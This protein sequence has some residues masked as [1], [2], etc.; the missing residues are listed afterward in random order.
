MDNQLTFQFD[1]QQTADRFL[2]LIKRGAVGRAQ[3]RRMKGGFQILVS[4]IVPDDS[5]FDGTCQMLD[6]LAAEF[7]GNEVSP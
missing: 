3:A 2:N 6:D 4:Y 7:G 1:S 5:A